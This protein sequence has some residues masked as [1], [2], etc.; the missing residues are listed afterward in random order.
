[1]REK[2]L[3]KDVEKAV[4]AIEDVV[5]YDTS[6]V[7]R[8]RE[9]GG[10]IIDLNQ[11]TGQSDLLILV[12]TSNGPVAYAIELKTKRG[13]Q[14]AVQKKWQENVW[15]RRFGDG[16]Y[17]VCRSVEEVMDAIGRSKE[18]G[19]RKHLYQKAKKK[20]AVGKDRD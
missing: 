5:L 11:M 13:K 14:S 6:H 7:G 17:H 10:R 18:W 1:M 19:E 4:R 2:D 15:E 12:A 16:H 8:V 20:G 3:Q 9:M